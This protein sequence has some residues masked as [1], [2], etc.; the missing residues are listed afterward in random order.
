MSI[1]TNNK[2]KR[3]KKLGSRASKILKEYIEKIKI[4][5]KEAL[6]YFRK[7]KNKDSI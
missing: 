2:I 6:A 5:K 3:T 1:K 7:I 4:E